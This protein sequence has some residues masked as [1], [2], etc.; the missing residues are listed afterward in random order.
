MPLP[1][2]VVDGEQQDYL[3]GSEVISVIEVLEVWTIG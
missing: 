3:V 1:D 2:I